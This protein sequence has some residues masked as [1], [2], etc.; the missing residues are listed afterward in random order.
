[1]FA[2]NV[3]INLKP[4]TIA[5]FT[6]TMDGEVLSLLRRQKGF[7]GE[8]TLCVPGGREVVATSFWEQKENTEAYN[9]TAYPEVVKLLSKFIDGTPQVKNLEVVSSTFEKAAAHVAV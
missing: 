3:S 4:N 7:K 1:M 2:R 8:I 9:T 6:K 5:E